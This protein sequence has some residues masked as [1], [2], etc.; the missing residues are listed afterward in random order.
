MGHRQQR[1]PVAVR[2]RLD[3]ATA[4]TVATT[5]QALATPSRV[6]ILST[7][8][9][10]PT[11]VADLTAAVGMAQSAVSHQLRILRNLGLVE[12]DREGRHVVYRLYDDHVAEL[13]D[14]AVD[15]AEHV[16]LRAVDRVPS[17]VG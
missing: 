3:A 1:E 17:A 6:L 4:K 14:H 16:R 12:G 10:G 13:I 8:R 11:K 15:H 2:T 5:L 9:E 7:L